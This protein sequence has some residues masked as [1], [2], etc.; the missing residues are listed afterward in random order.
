MLTDDLCFICISIYFTAFSIFDRIIR[1]SRKRS[2]DREGDQKCNVYNFS[3]LSFFYFKFLFSISTFAERESKSEI[4]RTRD[5]ERR[6]IDR[7][8]DK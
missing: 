4:E 1:K 2:G 6:E 8:I 7:Q 5:R 3:F